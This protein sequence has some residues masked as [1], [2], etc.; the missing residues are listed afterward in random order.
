MI[1]NVVLAIEDDI[2]C[3]KGIKAAFADPHGRLESWSTDTSSAG[4]ICKLPGVSCWNA[5]EDRLIRVELPSYELSGQIPDTLQ[6]CASLQNL[7]LSDNRISGTIPSQIC[8]WL[9]YLTT[10]DLSGNQLSGPI[11]ASLANCTYLNKLRLSNNSLSGHIPY[12]LSSLP[13]LT[14]FS[15]ANNHLSGQIPTFKSSFSAASFEGNKR[16]YGQPLA[17][18][19]SDELPLAGCEKNDGLCWL[20]FYSAVVLGFIVGFWSLFFVLLIKKEKWW[21]GYW[22]FVDA[23]ASG[24]VV[25]F[26]A[27]VFVLHNAVHNS[28]EDDHQ[29]FALGE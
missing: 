4:L 12:Q 17:D 20:M 3:L 8:T 28:E 6:Y 15:V 21:F 19:R 26:R 18:E 29:V 16:L 25:A 24:F 10:I 9:P 2:R 13:R 5:N 7:D 14:Y 1:S 22:S 27:P 23:V 11:P